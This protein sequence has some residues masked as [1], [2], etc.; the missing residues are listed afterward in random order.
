MEAISQVLDARGFT[1]KKIAP[2]H[3]RS[4]IENEAQEV[5][6]CGLRPTYLV[7][8]TLAKRYRRMLPTT[9][10]FV[11]R[12]NDEDD[13]TSPSSAPHARRHC[14]AVLDGKIY[15]LYN[16]KG[17]HADHLIT[18]DP[19]LHKICKMYSISIRKVN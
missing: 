9:K 10:K 8:G 4:T 18:K 12:T 19:Y 15:D 11:W 5:N 13:P 2:R 17:L 1:M 6:E 14:I 16:P 3:H 7:E